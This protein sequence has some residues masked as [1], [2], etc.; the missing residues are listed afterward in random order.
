MLSPGRASVRLHLPTDRQIRYFDDHDEL[1]WNVTGN[2]W[3]FPILSATAASPCRRRQFRDGHGLLHRPARARPIR[4]PA[5]Q[6]NGDRL[7]FSTTRRS[8]PARD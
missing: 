4:T 6:A 1:Y 2:G 8:M 3:I 5:V 7:V